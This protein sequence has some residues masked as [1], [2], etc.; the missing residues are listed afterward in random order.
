[1]APKCPA[2]PLG[3]QRKKS[4]I[5]ADF[6]WE[7]KPSKL[8]LSPTGRYESSKALSQQWYMRVALTYQEKE[9]RT[10][11]ISAMQQVHRCH[12]LGQFAITQGTTVIYDFVLNKV[13]EGFDTL[14]MA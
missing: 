10:C 4:N 9:Y 12:L 7:K 8:G 13:A 11:S 14:R 2:H 6:I 3:H 1:M 5:Q